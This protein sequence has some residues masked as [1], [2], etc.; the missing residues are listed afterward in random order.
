MLET[1]PKCKN[2]ITHKKDYQGDDKKYSF[3]IVYETFSIIVSL[4]LFH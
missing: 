3:T 4:V 2:E 1:V